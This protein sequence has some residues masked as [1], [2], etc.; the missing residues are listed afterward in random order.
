[1]FDTVIGPG[2]PISTL[3]VITSSFVPPSCFAHRGRRAHVDLHASRSGRGSSRSACRR[4]RRSRGSRPRRSSW[5][6]SRCRRVDTVTVSPA[7]NVVLLVPMTRSP[8]R[9]PPNPTGISGVW[10]ALNVVASMSGIAALAGT[11]DEPDRAERRAC[12]RH[13]ERCDAL[14]PHVASPSADPRRGSDATSPLPTA[15]LHQNAEKG[16]RR[17]PSLR[18]PLDG[19]GG[20]ASQCALSGRAGCVRDRSLETE[21]LDGVHR[22]RQAVGAGAHRG[23]LRLP[24]TAPSVVG[25]TVEQDRR[26]PRVVELVGVSAGADATVD[27]TAR[28]TA[29][30][31]P[32]PLR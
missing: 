17:A 20:D 5:P 27:R 19:L 26:V 8:A 18:L 11:A 12:R 1:M 16:P 9:P 22:T 3:T 21:A 31:C 28:R 14:P 25:S 7:W 10:D 29:S 30:R 24:S 23:E 6:L 2:P 15:R 32:E 13:R 4:R